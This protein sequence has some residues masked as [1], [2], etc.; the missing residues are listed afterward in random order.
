MSH[1]AT[2]LFSWDKLE[3]ASYY[4]NMCM[5]VGMCNNVQCFCFCYGSGAKRA[6]VLHD[7]SFRSP[8]LKPEIRMKKRR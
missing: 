5:Y 6:N 3:K 7:R 1:V 2:A 4:M 8:L